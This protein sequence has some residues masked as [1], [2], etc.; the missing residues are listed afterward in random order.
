MVYYNII[1]YYKIK[2]PCSQTPAMKEKFPWALPIPGK[3]THAR[4]KFDG[5]IISVENGG[6][7]LSRHVEP[8][9]HSKAAAVLRS[10]TN[11]FQTV[12]KAENA[13]FCKLRATFFH[14]MRIVVDGGSFRSSDVAC[15]RRS[16]YKSLYL[17]HNMIV[18]SWFSK[19]KF[20]ESDYQPGMRNQLYD[21]LRFVNDNI[22][23]DALEKFEFV[24]ELNIEMNKASI[25]YHGVRKTKVEKRSPGT[26]K[27]H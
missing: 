15:R 5:A 3:P 18:Q 23:R 7:Q 25:R 17:P 12:T 11:I 24:N 22:Q 26:N 8:S 10:Q 27:P 16:N 21:A 4:C 14:V 19:M 6:V 20:H 13:D 2:M 9:K 1:F